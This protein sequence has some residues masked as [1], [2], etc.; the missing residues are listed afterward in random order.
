MSTSVLLALTSS[1]LSIFT[2]A[3]GDPFVEALESPSGYTVRGQSP[4][5]SGTFAAP[6]PYAASG[7]L[8]VPPPGQNQSFY[9]PTYSDPSLGGTTVQQF[10]N[11]GYPTPITQDPWLGGAASPVA[12]MSPYQSFGVFGPQPQ[13]M[14]WQSRVDVGWIPSSGTSNPSIGSLEVL[15]VDVDWE[16]NTPTAGG[17]V[18][19][20][21]PQVNYRSLQGP[22]GDPSRDLPGSFYRFGLDLA[23]RLVSHNGCTMELGFTPAIATDFNQSLSSDSLQ[24]DAR[25][26]AYWTVSPQWMWVIGATYWDRKDDIILPYAGAVWTPNDRWEFRLIFPKPRA[27]FFLGTPNGIPTWIYAEGEYHVESYETGIDPMLGSSST[28]VQF[29]DW[30]VVGGLR[31][32]AGWLTTFF[33]GGYVFNREVDYASPGGSFDVSDQYVLRL[34]FRY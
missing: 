2:G 11:P 16:Y 8:T 21:G 25:A 10:G 29:S 6:G 23:S 15:E 3:S 7:P 18:F 9:A 33:E 27:S 30:R 14:G 22:A 31:W 19:S 4:Y 20:M 34:G 17:W 24:F 12:P 13:R 5:P 26:V 28:K 1:L 32:E